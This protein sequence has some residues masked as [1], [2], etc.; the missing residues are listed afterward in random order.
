MTGIWHR[1]AFTLALTAAMIGIVVLSIVI[2]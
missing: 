1:L 2:R